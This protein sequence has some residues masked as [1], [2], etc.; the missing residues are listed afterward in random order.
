MAVFVG[1][2]PPYGEEPHKRKDNKRGAP[3]A[4]GFLFCWKK[5]RLARL[6]AITALL[7]FVLARFKKQH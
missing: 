2:V 3:S 5:A 6:A 1:S 4:S 7:G